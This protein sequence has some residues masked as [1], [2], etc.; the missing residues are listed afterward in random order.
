[1]FHLT[2]G[3]AVR[4]VIYVGGFAAGVGAIAA[5]AFGYADFDTATGMFD[6]KPFNLYAITGVSVA[7]VGANGLAL[8]ALLRNWKVRK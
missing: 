4:G 3:A 1:M 6:L 8:F 2:P 7:S 5:A